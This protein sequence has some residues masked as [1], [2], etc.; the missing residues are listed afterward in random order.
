MIGCKVH[1]QHRVRGES[2]DEGE[3]GGDFPHGKLLAQNARECHLLM[4]RRPSCSQ[5]HKMREAVFLPN[6]FLQRLPKSE[7]YQRASVIKLDLT[8]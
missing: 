6:A 1:A 4:M 5:M 2:Q 7:K 8:I 3:N